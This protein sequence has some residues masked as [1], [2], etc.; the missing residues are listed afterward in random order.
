[1]FFTRLASSVVLLI[2]TIAVNIIGGP[3]L[4][5]ELAVISLIG[6]YEFNRAVGVRTKEKG[7]NLLEA[8]MIL[9]T[10]VFY[11][12][13]YLVYDNLERYLLLIIVIVFVLLMAV[14]VFTFPKYEASQVIHG[15]FGFI[16]VPV[17]LSFIYF[18]RRLLYGEY[19]VWLIFIGSWICDTCAYCTGMLFGKHKLAPV[20]SPKKSVEGSVGGVIGAAAVAALF[21]YFLVVRMTPS[22]EIIGTFIIIA[23]VGAVVSQV[24]DLAASAIKRNHNIKDYGN[25]IPGHGGILDRFD[26]VIFTA[27]MIYFLV[28]IFIH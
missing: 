6:L 24:G 17:M 11:V 19:T 13:G 12:T 5:C 7:V 18:T 23:A 3:V 26:S 10:I 25:L 28:V 4:V 27:P 16:Y 9:G 21:V 8:V 20:L 22:P 1:M 15:F 2:L 14:Y